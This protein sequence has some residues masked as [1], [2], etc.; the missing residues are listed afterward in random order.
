MA[1]GPVT[2]PMIRQAR[3]LLK[4]VAH[5]TPLEPSRTFSRLSGC[6]LALKCECLQRAGSYK[7]RGA[8]VRVAR[9]LP[10][11][12][13]R[14]VVAASAGN[15][16][17]GVA[18]AARLAGVPA[19]VVMPRHAAIAK[20]MAT[21]GYGAR[22]LLRGETYEDAKEAARDLARRNGSLLIPAFDDP[23]VV[24]G[25][26][27]VGLEICEDLPDCQAIVVPTG[28]GGLL[29]GIAV[30]A[31]GF[32]SDIQVFGVQAAGAAAF[33]ASLRQG[34]PIRIPEARTIADG[35]AVRK[36]GDITFPLVRR[37][38]DDVVTVE[39]GEIASTILLLLERAKLV[40]EG[41]GAVALAAILHRRLPVQ[42]RKAVAILSGG[43]IDINLLSRILEKGLAQA[44]RY[45]RM[46]VPLQDRPGALKELLAVVARSEGNIIAIN[47]DRLDPRMPVDRVEVALTV[48]M[49]D[50]A[51][52]QRL[53]EALRRAG[54]RVRS[55]GA[56]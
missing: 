16:A 41:A 35:I 46:E 49:R 25:Q 29:A 32:R 19:T 4:G 40:V 26:G 50:R 33:P 34:R 52:G 11:E 56:A 7:V 1:R 2:L 21:E 17:Q 3:R 28:G 20:I 13:R 39:D 45:L 10:R 9:L 8:Y 6:Q 47:H 5:R 14:G 48:E 38:V 37:L 51:H 27:T 12:R 42:G 55:E 22:V 53:L 43:N 44:G 23:W 15:H 30:A 54:F 36:P 31:K 18:L 24:A